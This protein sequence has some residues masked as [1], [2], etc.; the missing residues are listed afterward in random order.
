MISNNKS[1]SLFD[2]VLLFETLDE[3]HTGM[4]SA[5]NLRNFLETAERLKQA[6]FDSK[7]YEENLSKDQDVKEK[8]DMVERDLEELVAQFDL[9]GDRLISPEE[10]YNIIMAFYE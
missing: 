6:N 3:E 10:F 2:F 1:P 7:K 4:V 5:K 8:Y 9:T